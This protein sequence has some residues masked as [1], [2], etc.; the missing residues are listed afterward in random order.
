MQKIGDYLTFVKVIIQAK[1]EDL[2]SKSGKFQC[3]YIK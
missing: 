1:L 3:L 2:I